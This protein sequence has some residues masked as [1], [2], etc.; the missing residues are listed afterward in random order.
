MNMNSNKSIEKF[1]AEGKSK[2]RNSQIS[3]T[4]LSH[5]LIITSPATHEY[6]Q[7]CAAK[8]AELERIRI[9]IEIGLCTCIWL[10]S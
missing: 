5:H 9:E 2:I 8:R 4:V 7:H 6:L 3:N 10:Y 1:D